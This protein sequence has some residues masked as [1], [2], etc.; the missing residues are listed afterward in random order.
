MPQRF[1]DAARIVYNR[2]QAD[3]LAESGEEFIELFR[4]VRPRGRRAARGRRARAAARDLRGHDRARPRRPDVELRE[5]GGA[6]T[7]R[8]P[9]RGGRPTRACCS[10]ATS[11]RTASSR[12]SSATSPTGLPGSRRS[13]RLEELGAAH[14][15]ARATARWAA[16]SSSR[17]SAPTWSTSATP[18]RERVER[19]EDVETIAAELG[20][21]FASATQTGTTRSGST[22]RSATST[23][24]W[25][26]SRR[27]VQERLDGGGELRRAAVRERDGPALD[28]R[29]G[30]VRERRPECGQRRV[31]V[32][33]G[34]CADQQ[35]RAAD[36]RQA[37]L[38][39]V[40]CDDTVALR[41]PLAGAQAVD[42]VALEQLGRRRVERRPPAPELE[43]V[44]AVG[45]PV[46]VVDDARARSRA[47][48]A[49]HAW[50]GG[51]RRARR[52]RRAPVA[53][54]RARLRCTRRCG[55]RRRP[56]ARSPARRAG[57][58]RP[59]PSARSSPLP[60]AAGSSRRSRG[61]PSRS[62]RRRRASSGS[63]SRYSSHER[64]VWCS[65]STAGPPPA[66]AQ[67]TVPSA[68]ATK[69]RSTA[70]PT[71]A[72]LQRWA[73]LPD[74]VRF[75]DLRDATLSPDWCG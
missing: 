3:E 59:P 44:R 74:S 18:S 63:T 50:R 22:S 4:D 31:G 11:S 53:R 62:T 5:V 28:L 47:R 75:G 45:A 40:A 73:A 35:G 65:R 69:R 1:V 7:R 25:R 21:R 24:G 56:P 12:S 20:P 14:R 70:V 72:T 60:P 36:E 57:R 30:S 48:A 8:R 32:R 19:G 9:G 64:G 38:D 58:P 2:A 68:T 66:I 52:P 61:C 51:A 37:L 29:D 16:P 27:R 6:H 26:P 15:R 42:E 13:T 17:R 46:D 55:G 49:P 39:G 71:S 33:V 54:R 10:P 43:H 34:G 23:G 67:C 41:R